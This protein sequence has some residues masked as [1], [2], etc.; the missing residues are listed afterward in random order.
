[1]MAEEKFYWRMVHRRQP[2]LHAIV[3]VCSVLGVWQALRLPA[4]YEAGARLLYEGPIVEGD[5]SDD[6]EASAEIQIIREQL[7]TRSNLLEVAEDFEVFEDYSSLLPDTIVE[8]MRGS[9]GIN[10]QAGRGQA[11]SISVTFSARSGQSAADV[12]NEY[13]TRIISA[14]AERRRDFGEDNLSF[15]EQEVERLSAELARRSALISSFQAENADALPEDQDFRLNRQAVLQER[16]TSAQR[17][18]SS[19]IDQRARIIQIYEQTGQVSANDTGLSDDQRQLRDL[20][21][22]LAQ[23]LTIYSETAPRIVTLRRRIDQLRELVSASSGDEEAVSPGQAVLDLQLNQNAAQL[24]DLEA[25]IG[26]AERDLALLEDAITRTP[27][28]AITLGT[29]DREYQNVVGLY[30]RAADNLQQAQIDLRIT[31]TNRGERITLVEAA[32]VPR[33]PA[34]PNRKLIVFLAGVVGLGLA[35]GVF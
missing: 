34:S 10:S 12:V 17:E 30:D 32:S 18:L 13:V 16:Q 33:F 24:V 7:L 28:V 26:E 27:Q 11:T 5:N 31:E 9:S 1:M 21:R 25:I 20:E 3:V 14:S 6:F 4:T 35:A 2:L 23:A 22:E 15:Y 19:L 8:V 29:M